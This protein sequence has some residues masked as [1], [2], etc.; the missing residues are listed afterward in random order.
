MPKRETNSSNIFLVGYPA[1]LILIASMTPW[2]QMHM[3]LPTLLG[4]AYR[5]Q[6]S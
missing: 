2:N 3:K 1:Q 4:Q 5:I 6:H